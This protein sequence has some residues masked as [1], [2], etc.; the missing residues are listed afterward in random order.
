[1]IGPGIPGLPAHPG[2]SGGWRR[3]RPGARPLDE[4]RAPGPRA[5][6]T[7]PG[8]R[9]RGRQQ[10]RRDCVVAAAGRRA[11]GRATTPWAGAV[12]APA[13]RQPSSRR[14]LH[15]GRRRRWR[16]RSGV[17]GGVIT[18]DRLE[19]ASANRSSRPRWVSVVGPARTQVAGPGRLGG[20][21]CRVPPRGPRT[22]RT[23]SRTAGA[24]EPSRGA[25]SRT[26]RMA[27]SN[28]SLV[29]E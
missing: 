1:L 11:G 10:G 16:R 12:A 6:A 8:G 7:R 3:G 14:C 9:R 21:R 25:R 29:N 22:G 5:P 13:P 24:S 27:A 2:W 19:N 26:L 20:G 28:C 18:G 4:G 23:T 17:G 15:R